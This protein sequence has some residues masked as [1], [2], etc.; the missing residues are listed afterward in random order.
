MSLKFRLTALLVITLVIFLGVHVCRAAEA[1]D[2]PNRAMRLI[3]PAAPGNAADTSAR[4]VAT[5]LSR[6]VGQPVVLDNRPGAGGTIAT[7]AALEVGNSPS[8]ACCASAVSR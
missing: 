5:E 8:M 2:Y 3:V 4:L 6:L 7:A 1:A